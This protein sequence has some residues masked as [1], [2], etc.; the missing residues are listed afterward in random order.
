M[1]NCRYDKDH[2][3]L[4]RTHWPAC[5]DTSC[6]G[7]LPCTHEEDGAAVRHCTGR[8]SCTSHLTADQAL[9][10]TRCTN[11]V[12]A[13]LTAI[14]NDTVLMSAEAEFQGVGSE[15]L[16][17]AVPAADPRVVEERRMYVRRHLQ[18]WH[19][20]GR[21]D[22]VALYGALGA[23]PTSDRR[24]PYTL[25]VGWEQA[26]REDYDLPT[27]LKASVPRAIGFLKGILERVAQDPEQDFAY[28]AREVR[29]CRNHLDA[30]RRDSRRAHRGAPC[31]LCE[32]D[33]DG[34]QP[35]LV[36]HRGHWCTNPD[37][38]RTH[39]PCEPTCT[40]EHHVSTCKPDCGLQHMHDFGD[41]WVCPRDR[42]HWWS[43]ADY[44]RGVAGD[45]RSVS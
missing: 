7:C 8:A 10:C 41:R 21:I 25:A 33:E 40:D 32:P 18:T 22:D 27:V 26:F 37:C 34:A 23:I 28:F 3:Y 43:D 29:E 31:W 14:E 4:L 16:S 11:R 19:E 17:L 15:A 5:R 1:T 45:A 30:V 2:G 42:D 6:P 9:T 20:L 13:D 44:R 39:G 36:L 35:S 24:H 38:S 12:R